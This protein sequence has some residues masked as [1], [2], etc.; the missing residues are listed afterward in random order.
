MR[1]SS[2]PSSPRSWD[3]HSTRCSRRGRCTSSKAWQDGKVGLIAKVHHS[4]IDGVAGVQLMAQLLDFSAEGRPVPASCPPWLPPA[5][6]SAIQLVT[7][8][9][10][11]LL[12]SPVRA[13][14]AAREVGRTAV[15][16]ARR[17]LDGDS[18]PISIPLGAPTTFETPVGA[19]R[20]VSFAQLSL[21]QIRQLKQ[22]FG[23]TIND[24]VLAVC[25]G[26]LRE[27]LVRLD[28]EVGRVSP[29]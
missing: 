16:L 24:V 28:E 5:L 13:V 17:A 12:A 21:P 6:P 29:S 15:R 18:E 11:S 22:R 20:S 7:H 23:V 2:R 4:V 19:A 3:G 14:Q 9:L 1:P 27:H 26:A 8:A 25:S 10:P